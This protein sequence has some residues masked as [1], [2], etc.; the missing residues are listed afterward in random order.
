MSFPAGSALLAGGT[1]IL[2]GGTLFA[3]GSAP[4]NHTIGA[5]VTSLDG[6]ARNQRHNAL[7]ALK[8]LDGAVIQPGEVFSFNARVGSFN[9]DEGYRRAPVS[10]NGQLIDSWGGGVCQASTT[11]Y[12]A[13]LLAGMKIVERHPHQFAPSYVP[14]GRDAAVAFSDIDLKFQ[15]PYPFPVTV[16]ADVDG[17]HLR[18]Q[19]KGAG[20]AR[21][22]DLENRVLG[23]VEP[24][25]M[26]FGSPSDRSRVRNS[27]KEGWDVEVYRSVDGK[28]ELVS[29][30][31][32]PS[33]DRVVQ[34][35]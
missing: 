11:T 27:G 5:Y 33:M 25:E 20:T 15:N 9:R 26:R 7:L 2:L 13:A 32:Y 29:H 16:I 4:K 18:V 35:R 14:P 24:G 34:Y 21:Q 1:A 23:R 22:V 30:N 8:R 31:S 6:R 17:T 12:N 10:Y 19:L 3:V 28:R